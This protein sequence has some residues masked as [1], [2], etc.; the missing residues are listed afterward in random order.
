MAHACA[1]LSAMNSEVSAWQ[2]QLAEPTLHARGPSEM[3]FTE[4]SQR[5]VCI[6]TVTH[7]LFHRYT[8]GDKKKCLDGFP[9]SL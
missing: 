5:D 2:H 3:E 1:A 9:A 4:N 6:S 8:R 7:I